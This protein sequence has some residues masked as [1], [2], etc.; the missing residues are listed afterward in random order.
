MLGF[1]L[2]FFDK[3]GRIG[4]SCLVPVLHCVTL[5]YTVLQVCYTVL[6]LFTLCYQVLHSVTLCYTV[7]HYV[8]LFYIVLQCVTLCYTVLHWAKS[9]ADWYFPLRETEPERENCHQEQPFQFLEYQ[10]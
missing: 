6:H 4:Q 3:F 9:G 2:F 8:T 10:L 7:L 5:C 1:S